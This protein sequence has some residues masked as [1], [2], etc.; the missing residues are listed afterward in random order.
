MLQQA[1]ESQTPA[2]G[3]TL[4]DELA[5]GLSGQFGDILT[6]FGSSPFLQAAVAIV[7]FLLLAKLAGFVIT[8][9][10]AGFTR[11]TRSE[12][13]DQIIQLLHRPVFFTVLLLGFRVALQI[14]ADDTDWEVAG[15][16][17]IYSLIVLL[18]SLFGARLVTVIIAWA[19]E[20]PERFKVVQPTTRPLFEMLGKALILAL[21]VYF[22]FLAWGVNPAGWLASAGIVAVAVG[23]AAQETLANL[24]GGMSI[25]A[26]APY[27]VGDMIDLD[28]TYRGR[29][30]R[31]GLRST[32]ILTQDDI[33]ITIPNSIIANSRVINESGGPWLRQRLRLPIGVAY[34]SD[35]DQVEEV[36]SKA[37]NK[38]DKVCET[39]KPWIQFREFGESSL[40]FELRFFIEEPGQRERIRSQ[41][42]YEIYKA[43]AEA[44]IRIPFPQ[45]DVYIKSLPSG[46]LEENRKDAK[47][48]RPE[49]E[50]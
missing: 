16:T 17:I 27:K 19:G 8:R 23:L 21:G 20:H 11:R 36:L 42:N 9:G 45:R 38:V 10:V 37:L 40:N 50:G 22:V 6:L 3:E 48:Q 13:D 5:E 44:G 12:L 28:G 32:R 31:I 24:F 49:K 1:E 4:T 14:V 26:D 2:P 35:P 41:V 34:G 7:L 15:K 29:V 18:W 43:L 39:P 33:E 46:L 47:T 25:L 30:T